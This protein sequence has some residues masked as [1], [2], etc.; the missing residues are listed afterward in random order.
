MIA[1]MGSFLVTNYEQGTSTV[2][3]AS[4][5]LL[6]TVATKIHPRLL[7]GPLYAA[8]ERSLRL[9]AVKV[10]FHTTLFLYCIYFL[11]SLSSFN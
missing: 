9:D 11:C 2:A 7:L 1:L 8:I 6:Q 5:S 10:C 4:A 3:Q